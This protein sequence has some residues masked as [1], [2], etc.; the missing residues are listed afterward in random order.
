MTK[1]VVWFGSNSGDTSK[2]EISQERE[3]KKVTVEVTM[4]DPIK[5]RLVTPILSRGVGKFD[6]VQEV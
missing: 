5:M 1:E 6:K 4:E 2:P 3:T